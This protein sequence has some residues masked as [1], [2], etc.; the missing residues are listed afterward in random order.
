MNHIVVVTTSFPDTAFQ[1]GQEA[2]GTFVAD[3]AEEL[4]R[5]VH[6]TVVAPGGQDRIDS[7]DN[8]VIHR[9]VAPSLPLSLLKPS[10][11]RQ[12]RHIIS[13]LRAGQRAVQEATTNKQT[14]HIF[15][16]WAL[17]SGYW[18]RT[19]WRKYRVPYSI[20][21]LGS[22]IWNLGKIPLI[23]QSLRA[24]LRDS[25]I[26]FADGFQ[27]AEDVQKIAQKP[28]RFLPSARKLPISADK[29]L[30]GSPPYRL[31]FLGRWHLH[32]G[33]DLLLDS[34]FLLSDSDWRLIDEIQFCGGGPLEDLVKEK[35]AGL[36]ANGRPITLKGYLDKQEAADLLTWADFLL[37]PS[38]IES[39]PVIFSDAMQ[40]RCPIIST[41]I[42]DLPRLMK[43]YQAGVLADIVTSNAFAKAVRRALNRP[44]I[45]FESGLQAAAAEFD[46]KIVALNFLEQIRQSAPLTD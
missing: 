30:T 33:A 10:N 31:A 7:F 44:P 1:P 27:L 34:L 28:C 46:M 41:P 9:F 11:P 39:I 23:R 43:Q 38:R 6:V 5:H 36:R 14:D 32:K 22:D 15:A 19:M 2:A 12:W 4:A 42:G 26:R 29:R 3:F 8:L 21:A 25:R 13:T 24:V 45:S 20:W 18:A 37:L 17:P 40:A 16:L 35:C